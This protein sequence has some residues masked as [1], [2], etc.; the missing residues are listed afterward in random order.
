DALAAPPERTLA[1]E[2]R[3]A[4]DGHGAAP[5]VGVVRD[6][7]KLVRGTRCSMLDRRADP[8]G[9]REL[10]RERD[11][12]SEAMRSEPERPVGVPER[13]DARRADPAG[14]AERLERL[15]AAQRE[16]VHGS[17][18]RARSIAREIAKEAPDD[19]AAALLAASIA[20][21]MEAPGAA[22]LAE[23]EPLLARLRA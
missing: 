18:S 2:C 10:F 9:E 22:R 5:W 11:A 19:A 14:L 17:T 4:L 21:G 23:A 13:E 8:A 12:R 15:H 7:L 1:I 20:L 3:H 6:E 16:L